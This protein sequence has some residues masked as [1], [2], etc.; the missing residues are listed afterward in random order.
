MMT[1]ARGWRCCRWR[2]SRRTV[3]RTGHRR[4]RK[5]TW[6][7]FGNTA[8]KLRVTFIVSCRNQL[9]SSEAGLPAG[10]VGFA[11]LRI[12][13]GELSKQDEINIEFSATEVPAHLSKDIS[14]CLFR[15]AQEALHN[16]VKYSGVSQFTVELSGIEGEV[17]L[18]VSDA[19]AG[20]DVQAAKKKGGLGLLSMQERIRLVHGRLLRGVDA[21]AGNED[22]C[23]R[24]ANC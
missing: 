18:V 9:H 14:L 2:F 16:A 10:I 6:K 17:R 1:F 15:V 11:I 7:I 5:R 20:F 19:G 13:C 8:P 24:A 23:C 21:V 4:L 22:H 12:L 3:A